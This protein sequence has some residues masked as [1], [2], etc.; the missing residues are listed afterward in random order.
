MQ[1]VIRGAAERVTT[2]ASSNY[3]SV[4]RGNAWQGLNCR[5]GQQYP[6]QCGL[7][8]G[9]DHSCRS[10]CISYPAYQGRLLLSLLQLQV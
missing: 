6:A 1:V 10:C 4:L 2:L 7:M 5:S 3:C 9:Y 8:V